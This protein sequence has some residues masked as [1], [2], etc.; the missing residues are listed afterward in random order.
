MQVIGK[1]IKDG[2]TVR[3]LGC[4]VDFG[5]DLD[6]AAGRFGKEVVFSN[7]RANAKIT[8][9]GVI[10]RGLKAGESDEVICGKMANW[11]PGVALER[12]VDPQAAMK[13][14]YKGMTK[15]ERE[16]YIKELKA[17]D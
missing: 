1:D 5:K 4:E 12:T 8:A 17:M 16:A 9:R 2:K 10:V 13:A 6:D 15:A 7:Y 14:R 11:K 3:E